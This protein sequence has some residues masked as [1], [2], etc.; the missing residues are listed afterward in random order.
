M[1]TLFTNSAFIELSIWI[2]SEKYYVALM[3]RKDSIQKLRGAQ[4]VE[5]KS[6]N[7]GKMH[8]LLWPYG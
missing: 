2:E 7:R 1:D 4:D 8:I 5:V 6:N 3:S